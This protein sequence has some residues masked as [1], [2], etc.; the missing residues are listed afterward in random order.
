MAWIIISGI[1]LLIATTFFSLSPFI[2]DKKNRVLN[3]KVVDLSSEHSLNWT[4]IIR[5]REEVL[6]ASQEDSRT[7]IL[8]S[9]NA[10]EDLIAKKKNDY[11]LFYMRDAINI[12][13]TLTKNTT[14]ADEIK[15]LNL[16]QHQHLIKLYQ[17]Y[18]D[19]AIRQHNE[20]GKKIDNIKKNINK[21][22]VNKS[23]FWFTAIVFQFIGLFIG[24]VISIL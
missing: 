2:F 3:D 8:K 6:M 11:V 12:L 23:R 14:I 5:A 21:T 17:Q 19:L 1:S 4:E 9:V 16:P 15:K 18:L 20:L 7:D 22:E 24:I 13:M 10:S